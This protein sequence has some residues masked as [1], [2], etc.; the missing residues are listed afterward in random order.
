MIETVKKL[1]S[2][3]GVSSCE[4]E[5]RGYIRGRIEH[6]VDKMHVDNMGNLIAFKKGEKAPSRTLM[7]CAHMD[8]VGIII[9]RITKDGYLHFNFVGGIDRRTVIGKKVFIGAQRIE[10]VIGSKAFHLVPR[11]EEDK[12]PKTDELY[13]DIGAESEDEAKNSVALGDIGV[14]APNM[15][16]LGSEYIK[17]KALDDRVGCAALIKI[18][19]QPIEYDC[20]FV[21]TVQ[22]EVGTRGALAAAF[23]VKPDVAVIAEGTTAADLPFVEQ[24]KKICSTGGGIVIPFM[25]GGTIYDRGMYNFLTELASKNDIKWQTKEYIAGGTDASAIQRS[26]SGVRVAGVA[27][28]IRY[29]HSPASVGHIGDFEAMLKLLKLFISHFEELA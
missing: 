5:V 22:E 21:F 9:T 26:N 11:A 10:G 15:T 6:N 3:S 8:E 23:G 27:A 24:S 16:M 14:F 20:Y 4:D 13:I 7:L 19:E 28:A 17:A 1:C 2:L 25:D 29:I 12:I 18:I